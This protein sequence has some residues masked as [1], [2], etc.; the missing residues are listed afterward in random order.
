MELY[1]TT[2]ILDKTVL[3]G[4]AKAGIPKTGKM[5]VILYFV[6]GIALICI[7]LNALA[8]ISLFMAL[9]LAL[10]WFVI[11]KRITVNGNLHT[12]EESNGVSGYEFATWF[13]EEGVAILNL[14]NHAQGKILYPHLKRVFETEDI[15]ALQTKKKQFVPVFKNGLTQEE[16]R[17]AAAFLKSKN[18]KIKIELHR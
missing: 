17:E 9:F 2:G 3:N 15:L 13:D 14:T 7:K 6:L 11:F 10:W 5:A 4:V 16:V 18:S 12:M 1:K 8:A